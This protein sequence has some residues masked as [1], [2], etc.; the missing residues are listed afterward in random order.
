MWLMGTFGCI[1]VNIATKGQASWYEHAAFLL[2]SAMGFAN[3]YWHVNKPGESL[4]WEEH[5]LRVM[6][7][8]TYW[9]TMDA[10]LVLVASAC[11]FFVRMLTGTN[12]ISTGWMLWAG[13]EMFLSCYCVEMWRLKT[14]GELLGWDTAKDFVKSYQHWNMNCIGGM[15]GIYVSMSICFALGVFMVKGGIANVSKGEAGQ[16]AAAFIFAVIFWSVGLLGLWIRSL[17]KADK[18]KN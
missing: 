4:P 5:S 10:V 14:L 13:A 15:M 6:V 7:S 9:Y 2:I 8:F 11:F 18:R 3:G 1:A 16:A 17:D 12:Y